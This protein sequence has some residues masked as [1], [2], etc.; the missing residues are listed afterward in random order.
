MLFRITCRLI[1]C[2][3]LR[4]RLSCRYCVYSSLYSVRNR[5]EF[6][7]RAITWGI[8]SSRQWVTRTWVCLSSLKS[9]RP[10]LGVKACF[11]ALKRSCVKTV[12]SGWRT[13]TSSVSKSLSSMR[14]NIAT[15]GCSVN[16]VKDHCIKRSCARVVTAQSSIEESRRRNKLRRH[17]I[18]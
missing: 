5:N 10:V 2:T 18:P 17:R 4:T 9:R 15:C 11:Q 14:R 3:T 12:R 16:V 8:S 13:F 7:S 6:F 1:T